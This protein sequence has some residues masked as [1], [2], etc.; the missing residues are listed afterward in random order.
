MAIC[1]PFPRLP[2]GHG[3]MMLTWKEGDDT[4]DEQA[5]AVRPL[6]LA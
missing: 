4:P 5:F 1:Y 6:S 3:L 2:S